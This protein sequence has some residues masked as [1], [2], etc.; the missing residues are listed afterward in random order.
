MNRIILCKHIPFHHF[1]ACVPPVYQSLSQDSQ[2]DDKMHFR[3]TNLE[4]NSTSYDILRK[5]SL[6][7]CHPGESV[8]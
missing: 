1:Y 4:T 6:D 3:Y 7:N 8:R 5:K 2:H